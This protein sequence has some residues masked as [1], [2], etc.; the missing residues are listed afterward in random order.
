MSIDTSFLR[1]RVRSISFN[2]EHEPLHVDY[3][4]WRMR[5]NFKRQFNDILTTSSILF[6]TKQKNLCNSYRFL[7]DASLRAANIDPPVELDQMDIAEL[8]EYAPISSNY[9]H[10]ICLDD[11][12]EA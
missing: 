2:E 11:L 5:K 4:Y 1:Q 3:Q 12:S 8:N 7:V 6:R 10:A 9:F